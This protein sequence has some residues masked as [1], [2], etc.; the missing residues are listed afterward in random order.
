MS[1]GLKISVS[2][3]E[4]YQ[5]RGNAA[6]HRWLVRDERDRVVVI[7]H[8][9]NHLEI[10]HRRSRWM[11]AAF[12]ARRRILVADELPVAVSIQNR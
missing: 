7:L 4:L 1:A 10:V 9:L 6:H 2:P 8:D 12:T 11:A 5:S 3:I